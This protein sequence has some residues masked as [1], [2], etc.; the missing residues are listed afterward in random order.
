MSTFRDKYLKYKLKYTQ[1][2]NQLGGECNCARR[3]SSIAAC[4]VCRDA[5]PAAA[6]VGN[7]MLA[8]MGDVMPVAVA[9]PETINI[10]VDSMQGTRVQL[11]ISPNATILQLKEL[12]HTKSE[13]KHPEIYRQIL[14]YRPG[15]YGMTALRNNV[16]LRDIG[17]ADNMTDD[18]KIDLLFQ[19]DLLG[20][21]LQVLNRILIL[22]Q[23]NQQEEINNLLSQYNGTLFIPEWLSNN[24]RV[25]SFI[26]SLVE[27]LKENTS[28]T[29]L[30]ITGSD[31]H[32]SRNVDDTVVALLAP[33]LAQNTSITAINFSHNMISDIG[34]SS[35]VEA[36]IENTSITTIDLSYNQLRSNTL[37]YLAV[38]LTK[39]QHITKINLTTN[40]IRGTYIKE[41]VEAL[42]NSTSITH[43]YLRNNELDPNSIILLN[44]VMQKNP[45]ITYIGVSD[46]RERFGSDFR[47]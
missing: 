45:R 38:L 11:Q 36:L 17:I 10:N 19:P 44:G 35:L 21:N 24:L 47:P 40:K 18:M 33:A 6:A 41:F 30:E 3:A 42:I 29:S 4:P 9:N 27:A 34:V 5:M 22:S 32:G 46:N 7:A 13:L 26:H 1:L 25:P 43:I 20:F 14:V 15:P 16:I 2:K 37:Q 39:N 28:I 8:A 12:L 31:Q 23:N